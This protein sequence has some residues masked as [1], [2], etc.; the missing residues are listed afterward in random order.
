MESIQLKTVTEYTF[1]LALIVFGPAFGILGAC[2]RAGKPSIFVRIMGFFFCLFSAYAGWMLY[3]IFALKD[4]PYYPYDS[5][6]EHIAFL[7]AIPGFVAGICAVLFTR[8]IFQFRSSYSIVTFGVMI[9][10]LFIYNAFSFIVV[11]WPTDDD[12]CREQEIS[13][14]SN[15]EFLPKNVNHSDDWYVVDFFLG[16]RSGAGLSNATINV[17]LPK[18]VNVV[19]SYCNYGGRDGSEDCLI[20]TLGN[21]VTYKH[22]KSVKSEHVSYGVI[23]KVANIKWSKPIEID[24]SGDFKQYKPC[25]NTV[26]K[27]GSYTKKTTLII[28]ADTGKFNRQEG[29]IDSDWISRQ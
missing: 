16:A 21:N 22:K 4:Y 6:G 1:F 19:K 12:S 20:T 23:F 7:Y 26:L 11:S 9:P 25:P 10:I 14:N 13:V 17:S 18:E 28:N 29:M 2:Q 15:I 5:P 27:D 8:S 24:Y 3:G